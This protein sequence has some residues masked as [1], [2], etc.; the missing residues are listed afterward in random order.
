[1]LD[2]RYVTYTGWDFSDGCPGTAKERCEH[3]ASKT[4]I[5]FPRGDRWYSDGQG[6]WMLTNVTTYTGTDAGVNLCN[7]R[8]GMLVAS[9]EGDFE[10]LP[11]VMTAVKSLRRRRR[12][13]TA[14]RLDH[15]LS[16]I[17]SAKK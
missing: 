12:L 11:L 10:K 1:M 4:K 9:V 2:H 3:G 15:L 8:S 5:F 17:E 14:Q 13:G 6:Y 16:E 7:S